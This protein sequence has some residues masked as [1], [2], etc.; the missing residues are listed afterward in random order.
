V[1]GGILII[2][3]GSRDFFRAKE[4][5]NWPSTQGTI[6]ESE[7]GSWFNVRNGKWFKPKISY[8]FHVQATNYIGTWVSYEGDDS[9]QNPWNVGQI[10]NY[11]PTGK[12]VTVYYMPKNPT[13]CLLRPG[14]QDKFFA[15]PII[16]IFVLVLGV[17]MFI[18]YPKMITAW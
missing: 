6:Q 3:F 5:V 15:L 8:Y 2:Y 10:V 4:S 1:V 13:I 14:Q 12:V 11:Y 9:S 7:M 17:G 16:G 18:F